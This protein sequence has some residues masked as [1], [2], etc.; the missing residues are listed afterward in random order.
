MSDGTVAEPGLHVVGEVALGFPPPRTSY[1]RSAYAN[2]EPAVPKMRWVTVR[3]DGSVVAYAGKVEYGQGIR[4]G[5]AIEVADELRVPVESVTVVLA[6]TDLVPWDM[7]TFGSQSTARVGLQLRKAAATA[8]AALLEMA[9]DRLDL[10][11]SDLEARAGRVSAKSDG[12]RSIAYGDL[13]GGAVLE[14]EIPEDAP[15]TPPH[16]FTEMGGQHPRVDA[17]DRVTGRAKYSQDITLDGMLFAAVLRPPARGARV[18]AVD[19][20][21]AERMPGVVSVVQEERLVAVLAETDE[22]A[23]AAAAMLQAT[24]D[25]SRIVRGT[26]VDLPRLLVDTAHDPFVTQ[27]VGSLDDG[28]AEADHVLEATYYVPYVTNAP[29]EPRAA[30]ATWEGDR[31]IVWAG[32]QRPFGIRTELAQAFGIEEDRVRVITPEVGG[33]FGSK[34]PYAIAIEAARLSKVAGR[35]VRV[36][37]S[38]TDDTMYATVRPAALITIKSGFTAGG[39]LVAWESHGYHAGERPFLGRRGS[40][41]PYAVEHVRVTT[42]TSDSPLATGSYRSLGGAANHFARE[43]HMDEIAEAVGA[44]PVEL[45]LRNLENARFRRVL[46]RAAERHGWPG[47]KAAPGHGSGVAIGIDVGSYVG[48]CADVEVQGTEVRVPRVTA[49]LDCGLVVN[50]DGAINQVEGSV[51]MG[52]GTALWEA[53]D[54]HD[55]RILNAGFTRYRVPRINDAPRIETLLVG[56]DDTPS[57]GA[58]EPAIVPIAPAIS[59]AVFAATGRRHRELPITRYLGG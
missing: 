25:E 1:A 15:L 35:P 16:E 53:I 20:A 6:D 41:T 3:P 43:V 34:S 23:N 13:V 55:G 21:V 30:V 52:M 27:E 45:R 40:D 54:F 57:T 26:H 31:L 42:Y 10:P 12:A 22:Q 29:M 50:P 51:V 49:A 37:F 28:F 38:R 5:L 19:A 56:D 11:V 8:R 7:G 17:A 14:R 18:S 58:G 48:M 33:A 32:T 9:A 47:A 59:N 44:D 36:A 24:W 39:R 2:T 46:E 4:T